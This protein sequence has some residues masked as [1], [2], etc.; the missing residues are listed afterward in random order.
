M[1][2]GRRRGS[3]I[4]V[5]VA[6]AV[7]GRCNVARQQER[8]A[9]GS[10]AAP[11][12]VSVQPRDDL[13]PCER[14]ERALTG[15][16]SLIIY[17]MAHPGAAP[18]TEVERAIEDLA[19]VMPAAPPAVSGDLRATIGAFTSY[20]AAH[21]D[22]PDPGALSERLQVLAPDFQSEEYHAALGHAG[23]WLREEC[24]G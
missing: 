19:A 5:L 7:L 4:I 23:T 21:E 10:A 14:A 15:A 3:V 17:G 9:N 20:V 16:N 1:Q 22:E 24:S 8:L 13:P 11:P 18:I 6:V 12:A 2:V